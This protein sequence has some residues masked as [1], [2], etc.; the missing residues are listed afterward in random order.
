MPSAIF[1][2]GMKL[3][4]TAFTVRAETPPHS[5]IPDALGGSFA[6]SSAG[7]RERVRREQRVLKGR[8][9]AD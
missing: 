7:E 1:V 8:E 2:H 6:P 5:V 3:L 9:A 4:P